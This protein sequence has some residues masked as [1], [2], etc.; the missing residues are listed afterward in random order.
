MFR[1]KRSVI[2]R[3]ISP[4]FDT[5]GENIVRNHSEGLRSRPTFYNC[6]QLNTSCNILCRQ[7]E[8]KTKARDRAKL[9]YLLRNKRT[10]FAVT[11]SPQL[12]S[13]DM[14]FLVHFS[15]ISTF[16]QMAPVIMHIIFTVFS[17]L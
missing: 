8:T 10:E 15:L 14:L 12:H 4:P 3:N 6:I 1:K 9:L 5:C 2:M 16:F 17:F 7:L 13:R 11:L